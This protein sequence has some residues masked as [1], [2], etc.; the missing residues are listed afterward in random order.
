MKRYIIIIISLLVAVVTLCLC[1]RYEVRPENGEFSVSDQ[2]SASTV[3]SPFRMTVRLQSGA[4]DGLF[5]MKCTIVS[6]ADGSQP[7]FRITDSS[8]M[9]VTEKSEWSFDGDGTAVFDVSG[10]PAGEYR[11][12]IDVHRWYHSAS[13]ETTVKIL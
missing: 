13:A 8:K 6:A 10:V 12:S 3:G 1:Q 5:S 9:D 4:M 11:I 7:S 2:A